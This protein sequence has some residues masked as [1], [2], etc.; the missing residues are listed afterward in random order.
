MGVKLSISLDIE[1]DYRYIICG[2]YMAFY[3]YLNN[4]VYVERIL[5]NERDYLQILFSVE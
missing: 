3:R 5:Y 1:V 2:N 4:A